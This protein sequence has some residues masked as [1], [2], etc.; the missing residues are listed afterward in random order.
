MEDEKNCKLRDKNM[1]KF[2]NKKLTVHTKTLIPIKNFQISKLQGRR[3]NRWTA[4]QAQTE[5]RD[6]RKSLF[7]DVKRHL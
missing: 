4:G 3:Y 7:K 6:V 5:P 2:A 1:M